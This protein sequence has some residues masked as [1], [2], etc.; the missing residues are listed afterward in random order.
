MDDLESPLLRRLL[1]YWEG[2]RAGRAMPLRADLDPLEFGFALGHVSLLD[3]ERGAGGLRF[4]YR[5]SGTLIVERTGIDMRGRCADETAEPGV[6]A[7]LTGHYEA[8]VTSGRPRR[9]ISVSNIDERLWRYEILTMPLS[10]GGADVAM[11]FVGFV[12]LDE[13]E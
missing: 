8:V 3:V 1:A 12:F 9:D 7:F 4:R 2:K 10:T 11:L 6:R 13:D 5:L